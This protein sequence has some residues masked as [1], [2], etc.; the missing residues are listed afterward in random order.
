MDFGR[1]KP[2]LPMRLANGEVR[3]V[4]GHRGWRSGDWPGRDWG[5]QRVVMG[6]LKQ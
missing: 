2:E 4:A 1:I 5:G 3:E 6:Q